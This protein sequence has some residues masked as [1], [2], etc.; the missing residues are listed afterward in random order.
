[1]LVGDPEDRIKKRASVTA[2][3]D[4]TATVKLF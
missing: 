3:V 1:M 2:V 4:H